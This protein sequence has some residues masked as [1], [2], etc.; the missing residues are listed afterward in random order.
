[1]GETAPRPQGASAHAT[2]V[3]AFDT[4]NEVIAIGLGALHPESRTVELVA[5]VEAEARR[6]SNTQLLP[7][8]DAALTESGVARKQ[9]A[10]VVVG[11][12][13]GSFTGVRIAMATA[14]GVA[15]ALEVPLIGVSSLDAVAWN[16]Q[17]D[18]VRGSLA[19][20]ADAMRKEV[21]PVRYALD[22]QGIERLE[23][24]RVVKVEA[25][26][27]EL[28]AADLPGLLVA[29]MRTCSLRADRRWGSRSGRL[30]GAV[31]CWRCRRRGVRAMRIRSMRLRTIPRSRCRCTRVCPTLRKTSAFACPR[32]TRAI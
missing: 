8:I 28:S 25:A 17:A 7:R 4:A 5:S 23:A 26:A 16:A 12:G 14:K 9:I 11:R 21:Y 29:S 15:S 2:Y 10:C 13:P 20:V 19:V 31:F 18:G 22:D 3:L 32:T 6:A 27:D 1:M 24:D 30:R